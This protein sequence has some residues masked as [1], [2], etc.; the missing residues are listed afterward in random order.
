[1]KASHSF[2]ACVMLLA[3]LLA[4]CL[5]LL[6]PQPTVQAQ[7]PVLSIS[8]TSDGGASVSP[9]DT[10]TYSV[11][12][13]N[14]GAGP[15]TGITISDKLPAGAAYVPGSSQVVPPPSQSLGTI[16]DDFDDGVGGSTGYAGNDGT[17]ENWDADW[18]ELGE[19]D[20]AAAGAVQVTDDTACPSGYCLR[21]ERPDGRGASRGA[22]LSAAVSAVLSFDYHTYDTGGSSAG[23]VT[24]SLSEDGS[25]WVPVGT[26]AVDGTGG[27]ASFHVEDY[28]GLTVS[29][30]LRFQVTVDFDNP[31]DRFYV[32]NVVLDLVSVAGGTPP[33][34]VT[35]GDGYDLQPGE[36]MTVTYQVTVTNPLPPGVTAIVNTAAVTST[37]IVTPATGTVTDSVTVSSIGDFVWNDR[38]GDG[39][40]EP[41]EPG[42][43]GVAL[44][45]TLSGGATLTTTTTITGGYDLTG[46]RHGTYTVTVVSDTL[47]AGLTLTGGSDPL[48][49]AL[50]E[51]EDYDGGDF[52][53]QGDASIGDLV[54]ND[55][56]GDGVVDAGEPG[57]SGVGISLTLSSGA[58]VATSTDVSGTYS[59]A[60]LG[61][62]TYT[63]TVDSSTIPATYTLTTG[64]D[65]LAV[66]LS[67]GQVYTAA[68]FGYEETPTWVML[69]SFAALQQ[70]DH[71]RVT[72]ETAAELDNL[73]FHLYRGETP[74]GEYVRLNESL[75]PSQNP[76]SPVGAA[77]AWLDR[78]VQPGRTYYYKLED[79][80][81]RGVR[82]PHGPVG[83]TLSEQPLSFRAY[84]P[85]VFR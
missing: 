54:W 27:A 73:G 30:T 85:L 20:G 76:G 48:T 72:W 63:V 12:V 53:Y 75:I 80:D 19:T 21:L 31:N 78:D 22:N 45:L 5:S 67:A 7:A 59:F 68:R 83:V 17:Y 62:G 50:G 81:V 46:L 11:V 56:N 55:A 70:G 4:M 51:G 71:V 79:V 49:V 32:D 43:A 34:L 18:L 33:D 1:V 3:L 15:A 38:D 60:G 10:L 23:E 61:A 39:A 52:G 6:I 74:E 44:S 35:S 16:A 37:E 25:T 58:V 69:I 77:Y 26:Y 40:Q 41:G 13:T 14:T 65:P 82:T 66:T 24:L 64:N 28:V 9:G 57:I 42:L 47:P 29:T 8:K 2:R 84:L 36:S